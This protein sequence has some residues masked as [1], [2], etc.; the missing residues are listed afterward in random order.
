MKHTVW[1]WTTMVVT[2]RTCWLLRRNIDVINSL[3]VALFFSNVDLTSGYF[4]ALKVRRKAEVWLFSLLPRAATS[5]SVY[6]WNS[7]QHLV[8]FET[9]C[10]WFPVGVFGRP[11]WET[12]W[13]AFT[14]HGVGNRATREK[15]FEDW[16]AHIISFLEINLFQYM[17]SQRKDKKLIKRKW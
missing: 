7:L 9:Q 2:K 14:A 5:S 10:N 13:E 4:Y 15:R 6:Q 16:R 3:G 1:F 12:S 8:H 17:L 11:V